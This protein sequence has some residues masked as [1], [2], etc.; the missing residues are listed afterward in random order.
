MEYWYV[1]MFGCWH[2]ADKE[3]GDLLEHQGDD[4]HM[5]V[6]EYRTEQ[7]VLKAHP[8]ATFCPMM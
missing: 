5:Y 6:T 8:T 7:D 4:G 3:T 1:G 2:V